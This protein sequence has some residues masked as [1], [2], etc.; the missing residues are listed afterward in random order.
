LKLV[1]LKKRRWNGNEL[2][3][4]LILIILEIKCMQEPRPIGLR[5]QCE[6]K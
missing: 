3:L 6:R 4:K 1:S 2:G 5:M